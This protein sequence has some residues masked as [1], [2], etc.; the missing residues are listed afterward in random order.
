M[1][2]ESHSNNEIESIWNHMQRYE[3]AEDKQ[4]KGYYRLGID[5]KE[6][7]YGEEVEEME[8]DQLVKE[9]YPVMTKSGLKFQK[10]GDL[11]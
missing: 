9:Y 5:I 8:W 2:K 11:L 1:Y 3:V 7:L 6:D 4:Y 10:K